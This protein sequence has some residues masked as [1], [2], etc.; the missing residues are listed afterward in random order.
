MIPILSQ[1]FQ[2]IS[3]MAV[4]KVDESDGM[5]KF[6]KCID[7]YSKASLELPEKVSNSIGDSFSTLVNYEELSDLIPLQDEEVAPYPLK[8][9]KCVPR[10][11]PCINHH[12]GEGTYGHVYSMLANTDDKYV[13][14]KFQQHVDKDKGVFKAG[15]GSMD[16]PMNSFENEV[17]LQLSTSSVGLSPV[18]YNSW[19]CEYQSIWGNGLQDVLVMDNIYETLYDKCKNDYEYHVGVVEIIKELHIYGVFHG[20][21]HSRNIM[22]EK[23]GKP[24][25]I[26]FGK[27]KSMP[28]SIE[29]VY[30]CI[31]HD[32]QNLFNTLPSKSILRNLVIEYARD[33]SPDLVA[34][35]T[36]FEFYENII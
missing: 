13:A 32:L 7:M 24:V 8:D 27:S 3:N 12:L 10:I 35:D 16:I 5:N 31:L 22:V 15:P 9:T 33:I 11:Y 25:I 30:W 17:A 14:V 34:L 2:K 1:L 23:D 6:T 18:V 26:D 21:L 4:C 20:D 29:E 19:V 28:G 36:V